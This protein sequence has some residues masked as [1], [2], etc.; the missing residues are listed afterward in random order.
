MRKPKMTLKQ[1]LKELEKHSV[2][3]V[4]AGES[5]IRSGG[6]IGRF[7]DPTQHCPIT[8]VCKRIT[9]FHFRPR[10]YLDAARQIGLSQKMAGVIVGAADKPLR[11]CGPKQK[12][13]RR[14]MLKVLGLKES[15]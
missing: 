15:A 7:G 2:T 13:V 11:K 1:F 5:K 8:K 4:I 12:K 9:G 10:Y 6:E 14:Q 3:M